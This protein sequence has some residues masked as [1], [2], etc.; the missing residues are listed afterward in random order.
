MKDKILAVDFDD[1]LFT[2]KYPMIGEPIWKTINYCKSHKQAGGI[3]ILWTCRF[4]T[5]LKEAEQACQSV[6]LDFD[7]INEN[8]KEHIAQYGDSNSRK[9][10]ADVYL[11]DKAINMRNI[12]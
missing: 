4:G 9:I 10:Y 8:T 3:L 12:L 11:D 1:T 7:Y 6:G 2:D 5:W